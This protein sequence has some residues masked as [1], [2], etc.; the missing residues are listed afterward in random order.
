MA[1][2]LPRFSAHCDMVCTTP[3]ARMLEA[4]VDNSKSESFIDGACEG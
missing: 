1:V 4:T 3:K 2:V